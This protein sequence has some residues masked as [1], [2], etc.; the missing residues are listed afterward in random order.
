[1]ATPLSQIRSA[2]RVDVPTVGRLSE[3]RARTS[4]EKKFTELVESIRL[5]SVQCD[6]LSRDTFLA[7][8]RSWMTSGVFHHV[9]TL[10]PEMVVAA[11]HDIAFRSAVDRADLRIP[12]GAGLIWAHWFLRSH[13]WWLLPSLIAFAFRHVE[14]IPGVEVVEDVARECEKTGQSLYLLGGTLAQVEGSAARLK[15]RFPKLALHTSPNHVFDLRGPDAVIRDIHLK[16]PAVLLVAYGA[17]WQTIWLE[18]HRADLKDVRLAIGVGGAFAI[19]SEEK[20]RAP[21]WLRKMN[22]EWLWRL[23]LQPQRLP[24]IWRATVTFPRLI[25]QYKRQLEAH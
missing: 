5:G 10:N 11:E 4:V 12:D 9:I 13:F 14:R 22:L 6:F 1:M 19:I 24:R 3:L 16:K 2:V 25:Q 8:C 21:K 17:P 7:L 20:P 23:G 15:R 18:K